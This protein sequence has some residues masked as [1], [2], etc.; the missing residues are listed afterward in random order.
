[1]TITGPGRNTW[2]RL[3]QSD[4]SFPG[5]E[6]EASDAKKQRQGT[7]IQVVTR[8]MPAESRVRDAVSL[9]PLL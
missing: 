4:P 6:S 3:A 8:G 7:F 5:H 2:P 9:G 1:M